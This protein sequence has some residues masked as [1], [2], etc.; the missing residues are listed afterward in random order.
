MI[1]QQ[2]V[3]AHSRV[4]LPLSIWIPRLETLKLFVHQNLTYNLVHIPYLVTNCHWPNKIA[5]MVMDYWNS[6]TNK[7]TGKSAG[8]K[9]MKDFFQKVILLV[10]FCDGFCMWILWLAFQDLLIIYVHLIQVS[11]VL[12]I[13]DLHWLPQPEQCWWYCER[14]GS[15][16][17][18]CGCSNML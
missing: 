3:W 16:S 5:S 12:I 6:W 4:K 7:K 17:H 18:C 8:F 1:L 14:L 15:G 13:A 2:L 10:L 9:S 11:I